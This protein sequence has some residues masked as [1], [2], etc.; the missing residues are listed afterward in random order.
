MKFKLL[1]QV[2]A[3]LVVTLWSCTEFNDLLADLDELL[4]EIEDT[5]SVQETVAWLTIQAVQAVCF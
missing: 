2:F 5:E 1:L 4:D 3:V